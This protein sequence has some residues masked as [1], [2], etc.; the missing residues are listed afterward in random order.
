VLERLITEKA[1]LQLARE[2]GVRVDD[3]LVDQAELNVARQNRIDVAELRR[4]LTADGMTVT[5]FREDLRN[6]I[7]LQRLRDRELEAA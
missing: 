4:R 7:L 1:Q 6:Q 5:Q 3:A 2:T